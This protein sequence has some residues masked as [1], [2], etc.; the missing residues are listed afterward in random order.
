MIFLFWQIGNILNEIAIHKLVFTDEAEIVS[1]IS[2][3]FSSIFGGDFNKKNIS[4][5]R[6]FAEKYSIATIRKIGPH[7]HW[8]HMQE[9]MMLR[10][11]SPFTKMDSD[12]EV[13]PIPGGPAITIISAI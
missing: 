12:A 3:G 13:L 8:D 9:L 2:G 7:I 6:Q 1:K 10:Y 4:L 5:M 11:N